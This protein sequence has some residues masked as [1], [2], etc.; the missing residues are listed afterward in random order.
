MVVLSLFS[1]GQRLRPNLLFGF[2]TPDDKEW[3]ELG[4]TRISSLKQQNAR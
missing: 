3:A 2:P 1:F 4:A